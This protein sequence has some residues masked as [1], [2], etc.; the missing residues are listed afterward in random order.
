MFFELS[1]LFSI[2]N[3]FSS[4][5]EAAAAS[6]FSES[7]FVVLVVNLF[8]TRSDGVPPS[9]RPLLVLL[10]CYMLLIFGSLLLRELVG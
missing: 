7:F 8:L 2:D 6:G 9:P 1:L 10:I 5:S 3:C 4:S